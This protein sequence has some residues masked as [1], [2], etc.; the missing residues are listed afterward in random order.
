MTTDRDTRVRALEEAAEWLLRLR[1]DGMAEADIENWTAWLL[2]D[3]AHARAFDDLSLLWD[4]AGSD[5]VA[6]EAVAQVSTAPA[7]AAGQVVPV[8]RARPRHRGRRRLFAGLAVAVGALA[9]GWWWLVLQEPG[10]VRIERLE[11]GIGEHRQVA[12]PDGSVVDLGAASRIEVRYSAARREVELLAGAGQFSVAKAPERPF[13]VR[14]GD[15]MVRALGTRFSI[16][17]RQRAVEVVVS[18]GEVQ[19]SDLAGTAASATS[20]LRLIAGSGGVLHQGRGIE[21]PDP[22]DTGVA[23]AWLEGQIVYRGAAVTDVIADLNRYSA[24]PI[25]LVADPDDLE[26]VTGRWL[27][28]DLDGWLEGLAAALSLE[29]VRERE[30]ILL[31][32]GTPPPKRS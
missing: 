21:G 32:P 17:L 10:P 28:R 5:G 24:R 3:P 22:A 14:A 30:R 6:E 31:L 4:A 18:E 29:V 16:S 26:R 11:T 13:E 1:D 27:A 12:L 8:G 25:V 19:M 9:L 2:A 23:T 7:P 15:A 20:T